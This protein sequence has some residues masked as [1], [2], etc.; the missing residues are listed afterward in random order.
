MSNNQS[1]ES[2]LDMAKR[3]VRDTFDECEERRAHRRQKDIEK[4]ARWKAKQDPDELK[5]MQRT[6]ERDYRLRLK[7]SDPARYLAY[8]K[9]S[10]NDFR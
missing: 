5:E 6:W 2:Q 10:V 1:S 8:C 4:A 3:W 7:A 9:G